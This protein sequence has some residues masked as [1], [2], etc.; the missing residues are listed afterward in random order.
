MPHV[1][2]LGVAQAP[3]GSGSVAGLRSLDSRQ[4]LAEGRKCPLSLL[5]QPAGLDKDDIN[6][7]QPPVLNRLGLPSHEGVGSE[8]LGLGV[9]CCQILT[10]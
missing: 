10:S 3:S 9:E 7:P 4:R 8:F 2:L 6:R 1:D 5:E